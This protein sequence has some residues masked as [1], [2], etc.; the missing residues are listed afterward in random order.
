MRLKDIPNLRLTSRE[1]RLLASTVND[2][3]Y[4]G[5]KV[6]SE[7]NWRLLLAVSTTKTLEEV[8]VQGSAGLRRCDDKTIATLVRI[9]MKVTEFVE[10]E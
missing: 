7:R 4:N 5:Q 3:K 1:K 9:V 6:V 8:I 10:D 2:R